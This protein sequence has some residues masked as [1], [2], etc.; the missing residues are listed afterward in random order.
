MP[1][2]YVLNMSTIQSVLLTL[3]SQVN[4]TNVYNVTEHVGEVTLRKLTLK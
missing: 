1:I 3:F 2:R 4:N